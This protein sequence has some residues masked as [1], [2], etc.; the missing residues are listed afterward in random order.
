MLKPLV[1]A[2]IAFIASGLALADG[3]LDVYSG[4]A[5]LEAHLSASAAPRDNRFDAETG[6]NT[7]NYAPDR[8][9]DFI[10]MRLEIDIPDMNTRVLNA[11]Q[12]LSLKALA[13]PVDSIRLNAEQIDIKT[14]ELA[15]PKGVRLTHFHDGSVL[16]LTFDPPLKAG[17]AAKIV[18]T[19]EV[20]D[21]VDGLFWTVESPAWPGRPAQIHT[22]GQPETN[23]Y[24]FPCH[25]FPNER[26]TTEFVVTVPEDFTVVSNGHLDGAP[27]YASGRMTFHWVQDKPH[28][29]YLVSLIVGKFDMV[30]VAPKGFHGSLPVYVPKGK[31]E[32]VQKTYGHTAE[33]IEL[34]ER[35][36]D[37]PYPWDK[38]SQTVVWN[39]GA[40]GME[41]TSATTLFDTAVLDDK[42]FAD[43]DLDSLIAHEL[44]HQW[45]G[46]LITCNT[47]E[48]IWLNEG[49]ATY[50]SALWFEQRDGYQDGYLRQMHQTMRG[51]AKNDQLSPDSHDHQPAMASNEYK[52]PWEV[53]R[54][55]ANPYPKGSSI[56]HMLRMKL[57]DEVFF[58][59]VGEYFDRYKF[60]TAETDDFRQV[61]EEVSG[62][63]LEQFFDQ[64][65]Y[66]AGTP[67][68][69]VTG[70]WDEA[71]KE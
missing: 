31:G 36:F 71:S 55:K 24:W 45:T 17:Q 23:R 50:G 61:L 59:G 41:N 21:P 18:T 54:R 28:V 35:V 19:Y 3:S 2:S 10:H 16:T 40:G 42:A 53:F 32:L 63:S 13:M 67:K 69:K 25:D 34:F 58:K 5:C 48:H 1:A 26:L 49:W 47:W 43:G 7:R 14:V 4:D 51:L 46:D 44:C 56:L 9:V 70:R 65:C 37:E 64:W 29:S 8:M 15:E 27:K 60:K 33:M 20:R 39:F 57:G 52:H 68:V 38:Y 22:Q 30:E 11:K 62:L 6:R 12:T 66:R